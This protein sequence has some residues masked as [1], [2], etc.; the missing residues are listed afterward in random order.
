MVQVKIGA[1]TSPSD[2]SSNNENLNLIINSTEL[3]IKDK[4]KIEKD[5]VGVLKIYDSSDCIGGIGIYQIETLR[6][7]TFEEIIEKHQKIFRDNIYENSSK[8]TVYRDFYFIISKENGLLFIYSESALP[9]DKICR[10]F[11]ELLNK[12][13]SQNKEIATPKFFTFPELKFDDLRKIMLR[14]NCEEHK[15]IIEHEK[16]DMLAC[17][18]LHKDKDLE[19]VKDL[20][21]WK[22]WKYIGFI[23]SN[24]DIKFFQFPK[25]TTKKFIIN[26]EN[27][28]SLT[29]FDLI[30]NLMLKF[31]N[32]FNIAIGK[33]IENYL[34]PLEAN[35]KLEQYF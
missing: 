28:V 6:N 21:S 12:I 16:Y 4:T 24:P 17:G 14:K 33:K 1:L 29:N 13:F 25:N 3:L 22:A 32:V 35:Q 34:Y 11:L 19:R 2:F 9:K 18:S 23:I 8:I 27:S 30:F 7:L 20:R 31:Y 26:L 5:R 10:Y 15:L